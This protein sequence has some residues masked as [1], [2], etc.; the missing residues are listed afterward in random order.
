MP[1]PSLDVSLIF[2]YQISVD[3]GH[4]FGF[5]FNQYIELLLY[6]CDEFAKV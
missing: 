6:R 1:V 5:S 4:N 3:L 2:K